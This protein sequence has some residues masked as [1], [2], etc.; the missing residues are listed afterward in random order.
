M[1]LHITVQASVPS[2]RALQL[3]IYGTI[4]TVVEQPSMINTALQLC[5]LV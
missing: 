2:K 3:C 4:N 5:S 1:Q